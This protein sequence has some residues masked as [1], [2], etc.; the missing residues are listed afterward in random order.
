MGYIHQT[1]LFSIL[2]V[3]YVLLQYQPLT[4][5]TEHARLPPL[6]DGFDFPVG[7]PD[8]KGYYDAQPFGKNNHLGNDWNGV[9]GGDSDLGDPVHSVADGVV[10]FAEDMGGG[11]GNVVRVV[12]RVKSGKDTRMMESLY[13][14]LETVLVR[15]GEI[16]RRGTKLGTIGTA[17]GQYK[18][19]LH[20]EIRSAPDLP[21]GNGY[22]EDKSG[23]LDPTAFIREHR[24]LSRLDSK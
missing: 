11:W 4:E 2:L 8:A 17:N 19:H 24:P 9:G 5:A 22:S 12:H 14:H 10:T 18:A 6:A 23:Y 15:P 7:P 1:I 13:A 3:L 16:V 21:L 20:L